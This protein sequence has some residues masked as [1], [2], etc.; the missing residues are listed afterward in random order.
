MGPESMLQ[1]MTRLV[2]V[3][4]VSLSA[5][6]LAIGPGG[7]LYLS[8]K[9][10]KLLKDP[11]AGAKTVGAALKEGDEV[12]WL[13]ASE[14]NKS[15]HQAEA[16]GKKGFVRQSCLKPNKPMSELVG[17]QKVSAQAFASVYGIGD[18]ADL[19][20]VDREGGEAIIAFDESFKSLEA[21]NR[22]VAD[23]VRLRF[24]AGQS[25]GQIASTLGI[26][27]RTV[28]NRWSYAR[29]WLAREMQRA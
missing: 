27:D 7:S 12:K 11:K 1:R 25:V 3:C 9:D 10:V 14:K 24:F 6:A 13:G 29:T 23:V 26:S 5:S 16:A 8:C 18:G 21:H 28:N 22:E 17:E 4:A 2:W 20:M 19:A 15:F